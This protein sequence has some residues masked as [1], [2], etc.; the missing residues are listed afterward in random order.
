MGDRP[1]VELG[2]KTPLQA[3]NLP[4]M[5]ELALEGQ[6]GRFR[7]YKLWEKFFA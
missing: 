3:A 7:M 6:L 1:I 4:V 2:E 5:D